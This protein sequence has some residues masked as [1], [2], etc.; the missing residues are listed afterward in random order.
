MSVHL[1]RLFLLIAIGIIVYSIVKYFLD[2]RRKLEAACHQ[3]GFYFLDDPDNVRKNL[4]F[5]Y[6]G[7]MFEGEKFLGATDGSFEVTSI[8]VWTEDTDRLKG[9]SIKDFHFMEKEILLH[10]PKAEIEWKSPIRELLKQ[11][12]KER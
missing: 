10:Y 5:T 12:K 9:L 11:M 1:F 8:I 2:P 6:R 3:G 7:V 4:L